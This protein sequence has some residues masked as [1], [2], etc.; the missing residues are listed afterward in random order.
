MSEFV[1]R[2]GEVVDPSGRRAADVLVRDGAVVE[3]GVGLEAAE[4][5]DATGAIVTPGFVDLHT[6]LREPGDEDAETIETGSRAAACGGY[7]AVVAMPNTRPPLDD[8]TILRAVLAIGAD[9]L[10]EVGSS[11]CIRDRKSTRLNSS[12]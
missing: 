2:G 3:V 5:L 4:V 8:P 6:H 1:I 11:G 7:T 12:H 10:C 9:A